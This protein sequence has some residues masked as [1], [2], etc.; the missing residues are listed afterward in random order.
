[1]RTRN[2]IL[3]ELR[4]NNKNIA[5]IDGGDLIRVRKEGRLCGI[6]SVSADKFL[7]PMDFTGADP[8]KDPDKFL[9]WKIQAGTHVFGILSVRTQKLLMPLEYDGIGQLTADLFRFWRN[10]RF[11]LYSLSAQ[12]EVLGPKYHSIELEG[13]QL[14]LREEGEDSPHLKA[15]AEI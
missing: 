14:R 3:A 6:Y 11:G 5:E 8:L 2:E 13:D 15:L 7:V 1:M 10:R 12:K 9:V 4:L